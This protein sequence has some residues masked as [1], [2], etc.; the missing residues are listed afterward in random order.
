[1]HHPA[2]K[3]NPNDTLSF[4]TATCT[5]GALLVAHNQRG[6]CAI[7]LGDHESELAQAFAQRFAHAQHSQ[8]AAQMAQ[9]IRFIE[10]PQSTL[11]LPLDI[12]GTVFQLRVWQALRAIPC[13]STASYR[14]IATQIGAPQAARAVA[15]AC[16]ANPLAVVIPCHRVVGSD[17]RLS[18]YRWGVERKVRLLQLEGAL[19]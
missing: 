13:G 16:A 8:P 1:M 11:N 3:Q 19:N 5:L 17:G 2:D 10:S 15:G 14:E 7:Q 4:S 18:G 12:Q 9:I 6:V